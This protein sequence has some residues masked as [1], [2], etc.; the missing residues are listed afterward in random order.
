MTRLGPTSVTPR[1]SADIGHDPARPAPMSGPLD[2]RQDVYRQPD[3]VNDCKGRRTGAVVGLCERSLAPG[4]PGFALQALTPLVPLFGRTPDSGWPALTSGLIR[5]SVQSGSGVT[6]RAS[7]LIGGC[8][9]GLAR[10]GARTRTLEASGV[11]LEDPIEVDPAQGFVRVDLTGVP[12]ANR[13]SLGTR[14][15]DGP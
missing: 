3:A 6:L 10:P 4:A 1:S 8:S 12:H 2:E 15:P 5:A 14:T 7:P 11:E 13:D 9:R